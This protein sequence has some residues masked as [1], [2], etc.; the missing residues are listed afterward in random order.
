MA[1]HESTLTMSK[2]ESQPPRWHENIQFKI[3]LFLVITVFTVVGMSSLFSAFAMRAQLMEDAQ[4]LLTRVGER[5]ANSLVHPMWDIDEELTREVLIAEMMDERITALIVRDADGGINTGFFRDANG[6]VSPISDALSPSDLVIIEQ[7]IEIAFEGEPIGTLEIQV[8]KRYVNTALL[9][10]Y[11]RE[12][13]LAVL[14]AALLVVA[15]FFILRR[16]L[17]KPLTVMTGLAEALSQGDR[18]VEIN[19]PK[20]GEIRALAQAL[21]VFKKQAIHNHHLQQKQAEEVQKRLDEEAAKRQALEERQAMEAQLHSEKLELAQQQSEQAQLLKQRADVLLKV[22][23]DAANGD[24]TQTLSLP[25]DDVIALIGQRLDEFFVRLRQS[26]T[27]IESSTDELLHASKE[28]TQSNESITNHSTETT[29]QAISVSVSADEIGQRV[30]GVAAIA[31]ELD[32]S[33][34][35]IAE[36]AKKATIAAEEAG[37]IAVQTTDVVSRLTESS[38]GIGSVIKVITSIA[39]QTN[40]LAL[41]ATIEAARA[42]DA[43]KGF[44]VVANEVKELA[45]ETAKATE[46]ISQRIDAIQSDSGN[47]TQA[48]GDINE[49]IDRI[50]QMQVTVAGSVQEQ[51]VSTREISETI[52]MT[53]KQSNAISES[54]STVATAAE[55]TQSTVNAACTVA[56]EVDR[57]ATRLRESI[58]TFTLT[59]QSASRSRRDKTL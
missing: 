51:S 30:N 11:V 37:Q 55:S 46:E 57:I 40:L 24:L 3:C 31:H 59:D 20:S 12:F 41:N 47:V 58:S 49:I 29:H 18:N 44:A 53:S 4:E 56:S 33:V 35:R 2:S 22:V 38:A 50:N 14:L 48:I 42:G 15:M 54:I 7:G 17:L 10:H 9:D 39:E 36:D 43:G 23:E 28:L 13:L 1:I 5:T 21:L 25:G 6:Q 8:S 26:L 16:L 45:K 34:K 32:T 52:A 27:A 19:L